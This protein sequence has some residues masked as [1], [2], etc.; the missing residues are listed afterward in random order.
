MTLAKGAGLLLV[1]V[2]ATISAAHLPAL[3]PWLR[4]ATAKLSS[5]PP[6][7]PMQGRRAS[8]SAI[9]AQRVSASQTLAGSTPA[10]IRVAGPFVLGV[11]GAR[12]VEAWAAMRGIRCSDE[13]S[14]ASRRCPDVP[15]AAL[16]PNS[17]H[18]A[19]DSAAAPPP[20]DASDVLFRFNADRALV[21]VD[22]M[23]APAPSDVA[24]KLAAAIIARLSDAAGAA[25]ATFGDF[26]PVALE[27]PGM[28]MARAEFRFSDY[29]ADV[30]V[31]RLDRT[32][33][34]IVREE[35]RS[36]GAGH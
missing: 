1:V 18:D 14:G 16:S 31:S 24:V 12:D 23:R 25:R 15:A 3:H 35:Y 36:V 32:G 34:L 21:A 9:E 10:R 19:R 28:R 27:A 6:S 33:P 5:G 20:L 29:A 26:A 17:V 22:V 7:C 13:L 4:A 11:S 2:G 8:S 30:S